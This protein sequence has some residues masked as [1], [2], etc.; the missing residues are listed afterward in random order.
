MGRLCCCCWLLPAA[1]VPVSTRS[2]LRDANSSGTKQ[3]V[4]QLTTN[5]VSA[6][7][8]ASVST[9]AGAGFA[10]P[11]PPPCALPHL[12][13]SACHSLCVAQPLCHAACVP[14]FVTA[15]LGLCVPQPVHL[16]FFCLQS[17]S[18]TSTCVCAVRVTQRVCHS[19]SLSLC[20]TQPLSHSMSLSLCVTQPLCHSLS[21]S[22]CVTQSLS[23]S[24]SVSLSFSLTRS[25]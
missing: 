24:A 22:L 12:L 3:Q 11:P 20:V 15:A 14:L 23:H 19:A 9:A 1:R 17:L 13:R 7:L 25:L 5:P 16:T 10:V 21:L 4:V 18:F 6:Q 2:Q 8:E